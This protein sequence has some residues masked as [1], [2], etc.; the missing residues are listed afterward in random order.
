MRRVVR[1]TQRA[2]RIDVGVLADTDAQLVHQLAPQPGGDQRE[3]Q[4]E[5]RAHVGSGRRDSHG[6]IA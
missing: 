6:V 5:E 2:R 4:A 3:P 1:P